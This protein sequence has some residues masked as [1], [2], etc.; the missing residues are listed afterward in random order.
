MKTVRGEVGRHRRGGV[1]ELE[2]VAE[3]EVEA[4]PGEVA[5]A[6]LE[7]G[8]CLRLDLRDLGA[9]LVADGEQPLVRERVPAGIAHR[10][11]AEQRDLECRG[12]RCAGGRRLRREQAESTRMAVNSKR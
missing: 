8:R 11:R 9:E 10:P 7:L 5:E 6:R 12:G 2:A 3:D 4:A 1:L